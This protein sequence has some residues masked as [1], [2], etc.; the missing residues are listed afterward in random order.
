MTYF[1]V[2]FSFRY[3]K[4]PFCSFLLNVATNREIKAAIL[5]IAYVFVKNTFSGCM[6]KCSVFYFLTKLTD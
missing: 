2:I 6:T 4:L 1:A 3:F 5:K